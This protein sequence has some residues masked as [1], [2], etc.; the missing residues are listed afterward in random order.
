MSLRDD[1]RLLVLNRH[2]QSEMLGKI[3]A[4]SSDAEHARLDAVDAEIYRLRAI[5]RPQ[6]EELIGVTIEELGEAM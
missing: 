4:N 6:V 1:A 5:V 3:T 2:R